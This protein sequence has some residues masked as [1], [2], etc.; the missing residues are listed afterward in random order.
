MRSPSSV[1]FVLLEPQFADQQHLQE[2]ADGVGA[3]AAGEEIRALDGG[4][5]DQ[6]GASH[7]VVADDLGDHRAQFGF[8]GA[9]DD[10]GIILA[11]PVARFLFR[12]RRGRAK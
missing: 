9:V 10:V 1:A 7:H 4:G 6:Q 5:A 11:A 3:Q 2:T 8:H 12:R